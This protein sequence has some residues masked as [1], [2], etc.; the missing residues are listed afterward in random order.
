MYQL[1]IPHNLLHFTTKRLTIK[2]AIQL[3]FR[4]IRIS[5]IHHPSQ[6]LQKL[7]IPSFHMSSARSLIYLQNQRQVKTHQNNPHINTFIQ[8]LTL[9]TK[10]HPLFN[11]HIPSLTRLSI[12]ST[13]FPINFP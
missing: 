11:T 1:Q 2:L 5:H 12:F 7:I 9:F 6:S 10:I 3:L 8:Q 4:I 13:I